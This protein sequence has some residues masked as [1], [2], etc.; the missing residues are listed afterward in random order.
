[1]MREAALAPEAFIQLDD[2]REALSNAQASVRLIWDNP[3]MTPEEKRQLIDSMYSQMSAMA[4]AGNEI[5]REARELS[6]AN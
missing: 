5:L 4:D 2:V 1:M 3:D 6:R